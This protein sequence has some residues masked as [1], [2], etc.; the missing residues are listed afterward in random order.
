VNLTLRE[1]DFT[2]TGCTFSL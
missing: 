2:W 1:L